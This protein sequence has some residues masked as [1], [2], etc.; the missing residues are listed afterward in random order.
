MLEPKD[1]LLLL[2]LL[3]GVVIYLE[4]NQDIGNPFVKKLSNQ[5]EKEALELIT[6]Q[7]NNLQHLLPLIAEL[8]KIFEESATVGNKEVTDIE[9][10]A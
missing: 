6:N 8:N 2:Q 5:K 10:K 7:V 3:A 1:Q 9:N 4:A